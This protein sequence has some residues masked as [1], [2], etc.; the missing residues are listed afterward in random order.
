MSASPYGAISFIKPDK[1]VL[2]PREFPLAGPYKPYDFF[3]PEVMMLGMTYMYDGRNELG[4]EL[5]RRLM[6]DI[7]CRQ[8]STWYMPNIILGDTGKRGFGTDYYQNM[9]LW[10]LPAALEGKSLESVCRSGG[11]VNRMVKAAAEK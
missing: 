6:H 5:T 11:L 8:G 4:L 2:R 10:S 7:V 9:M 3:V 1:T